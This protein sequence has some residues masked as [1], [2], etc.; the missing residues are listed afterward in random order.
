VTG[1]D[2][3][4]RSLVG[5]HL[6]KNSVGHLAIRDASLTAGGLDLW[7]LVNKNGVVMRNH[8][9]GPNNPPTS[10]MSPGI[11]K[12]IFDREV[13][14]CSYQATIGSD[15]AGSPPAQ[16]IPVQDSRVAASAVPG[17][18]EAVVVR[19]ANGANTETDSA[20]QLAVIC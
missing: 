17:E 12:V 4:L 6:R 3:H 16:D 19:T 7:A 15:V 9:L 10:K 11:Y 2:I 14:S 5:K 18:K 1:K 20:F 8:G 13:D